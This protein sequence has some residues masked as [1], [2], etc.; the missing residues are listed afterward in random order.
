MNRLAALLLC[1]VTNL[2]CF[3]QEP[4]KLSSP[5]RN[6][7]LTITA[8]DSLRFSLSAGT[9]PVITQAVI[10]MTLDDGITWGRHTQIVSRNYR[11]INW[12]QPSPFY[13]KATVR[14]HFNE[15][16]LNFKGD[17]SVVLRAYDEGVAYR[18]TSSKPGAYHVFAEQ[19]TYHFSPGDSAVAAYV[20]GSK[21]DRFI[22]S[23]ENT[24]NFIALDKLNE[25]E[26]LLTPALICKP[27]KCAVL[28]SESDLKSYPGMYL[29][30][31]GPGTAASTLEAVFAPCPAGETASEDVQ[32]IHVKS[33]HDYIAA[34]DG[35][36][37]FP[38]RLF[39]V[40]AH[41]QDFLTSDLPYL[42]AKPSV[43]TDLTWIK[44]GKVS[45][46]WWADWNIS[47]VGFRSGVN[48][49]TYTYHIDFASRN[50][51]EYILLDA[52]WYEGYD[53][54]KTVPSINL[55]YLVKYGKQKNV[56]IWL[57]LGSSRLYNQEEKVISHYAA[58]GI[59]GFK[60]DF[61]DRDDQLAVDYVYKLLKIAARYHLMLDLHG[62]FKPCGMQRE[63]PNLVGM[64]GVFGLENLKWT[65][66]TDFPV[67]QATLPFTRMFAGMM[68]YTP[69]AMRNATKKDFYPVNDRPMS[70]GTRCQ[71]LALYA[72]Y[73]V[74]LQML[75]D[76][77][78]TYGKEEECTRFIS[79][80][81][82]VWDSTIPLFG[83]AGEYV[84]LARRKGTKWYAGCITNWQAR[85][86]TIDCAFLGQ[87]SYSAEIFE[88]GINA[89]R[90]ADDYR[91]KVA[92]VTRNSKITIHLAAGGGWAGIFSP[93]P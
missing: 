89:D 17:Y 65:H 42:L 52:G 60:I 1:L 86:L 20:N 88:D 19:A 61:F 63:Y 3:A 30:R 7:V 39:A 74:P 87:G 29:Q 27:G 64:E 21:N 54:L 82:T 38:W 9:T 77:P 34:V 36:R 33:R 85:D 62:V 32:E 31:R 43:I 47:G 66:Y 59:K 44:P 8:G 28:I 78:A 73:Y 57:W 80:F 50:S 58:L 10:S 4:I 2:T 13:I 76:D 91:R 51:L 56:G 26:L 68:D 84:G 15:L 41:E 46:D 55:P 11:T 79:Q 71:Q 69:G 48:D 75:A 6:L 23:F 35:P 24:Y 16:T 70:Q 49:S 93:L 37:S 18:F 22:N 92:T 90:R 45:W 5:S 72:L 25:K 53:A 83:R 67:H 12:V 14:D 40:A 81:P